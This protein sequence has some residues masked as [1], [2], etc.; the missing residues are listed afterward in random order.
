MNKKN[1][2]FNVI[3]KED[4]FSQLLVNLVN[5]NEELRNILQNFFFENHNIR[6]PEFVIDL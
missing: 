4:Q 6:L 5:E 3:K 2:F 1:I